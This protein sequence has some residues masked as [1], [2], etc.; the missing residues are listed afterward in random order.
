MI[1]GEGRMAA[2]TGNACIGQ[3]GH[4][5]GETCIAV[6]NMMQ[7]DSVWETVVD[8]FERRLRVARDAAYGGAA[9]RRSVSYPTH[10]ATAVPFF[11]RIRRAAIA[12]SHN[13]RPGSEAD[14]G[15]RL[16]HDR[17]APVSRHPQPQR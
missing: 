10:E 5:L 12:H 13:G 14:I 3:A 1:D 2:Y 4:A 11:A 7:T 9:R 8:A 16:S 15:M 6:A 17:F